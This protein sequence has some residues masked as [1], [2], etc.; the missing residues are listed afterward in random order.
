MNMKGTSITNGISNGIS[1][2]AQS[3]TPALRSWYVRP[4]VAVFP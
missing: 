3:L 2:G 4:S 1:K